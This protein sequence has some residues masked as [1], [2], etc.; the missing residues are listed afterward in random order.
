MKLSLLLPWALSLALLGHSTARGH[1]HVEVGL[2]PNDPSRLALRGPGFQLALYVPRG[3]PFSGYLPQFPGGAY[4]SQLTFSAEG[5]SID[6]PVGSQSRIE[7]I[8]VVGPPQSSLSFWEVGATSP[9]WTRPAGWTASPGGEPSFHVYEEASGYGH[10]HGRAFT[11][12]RPG[13]YQVVFRATDQ[14]GTYTAS[15][16]HH[17]SFQAQPPPQLSIR[18]ANDQVVLAFASEDYLTYDLQISTTL[19]WDSWSTV[20][21]ANGT[22]GPMHF[23]HGIGPRSRAFYRLVAY[24]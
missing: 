8:S 20:D 22:G 4:A 18:I 14:T 23:T 5:N 6:F 7:L 17:I 2:D 12:D 24:R 16:P 1:D 3:E 11:F 19:A 9:T 21:W 10:L 15:L 13:S